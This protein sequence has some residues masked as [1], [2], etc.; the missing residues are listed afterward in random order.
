MKPG[1]HPDFYRLPPPPG[2]SRESGI[3]LDREGR[4]WHQG[5][6]VEHPAMARAFHGWVARHPDDGRYILDNGFDWSYLEVQDVPFFVRSFGI[7][8]GEPVVELSDGTREVLDP[9]TLRVGPRDA[10][11]ADV[12]GGAMPARFMPQAQAALGLL[13]DDRDG[14]WVLELGGRRFAISMGKPGP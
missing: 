13:L 8:D 3:V 11:Y 7:V 4:F 12:K 2:R 14:E 6:L 10:L 1:D 9:R 5:K